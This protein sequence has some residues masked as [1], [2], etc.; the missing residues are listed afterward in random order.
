MDLY[1]TLLEKQWRIR[2]Q[3]IKKN[4]FCCSTY[5]PKGSH[6]NL[7]LG[8]S[9]LRLHSVLLY[10][11]NHIMHSIIQELS[12]LQFCTHFLFLRDMD[13]HAPLEPTGFSLWNF[14]CTRS[15]ALRATLK[16]LRVL[17]DVTPSRCVTP[18]RF[19]GSCHLQLQ[20]YSVHAELDWSPL[21]MKATRSS[22]T[23]GTTYPAT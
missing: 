22:K 8:S 14:C 13:I 9:S 4:P 20:R 3:R 2:T 23:Q 12:D 15:E 5:V 21:K 10:Y 1:I 18:W 16:K 19:K 7:S 6:K 11:A 17:W